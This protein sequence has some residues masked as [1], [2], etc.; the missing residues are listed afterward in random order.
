MKIRKLRAF[1]I[2]ELIIVMLISSVVITIAYT[3]LGVFYR[4]YT[5]F[6]HT[7]EAVS[8][9]LLLDRL[10]TLD[11]S[12]CNYVEKKEGG[13]T[14]V[15]ADKEIAYQL[16]DEYI[17]RTEKQTADTFFMPNLRYQTFFLQEEVYMAE[18]MIDELGI[19]Y[20][21]SEENLHVSY[22]KKY[23]ADALLNVPKDQE[24]E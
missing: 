10:L 22:T 2:I 24:K 1:T 17:L 7:Q 21:H 11:F 16:T 9:T 12:N 4:Q 14:C 20:L 23:A 8:Q 13:I 3:G 6:K 19:D 5:Q 18:K 15:Y